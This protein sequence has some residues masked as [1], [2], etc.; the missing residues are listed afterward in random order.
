MI[1]ALTLLQ[2][3]AFPAQEET[4]CTL[5]GG[6][7]VMIGWSGIDTG[8]NSCN[9]CSCSAANALACTVMACETTE[10][11]QSLVCKLT[12]GEE[13]PSGWS[14]HDTGSNW[15]NTC[16]CSADGH[17]LCSLALCIGEGKV[18]VTPQ[19]PAGGEDA[20]EMDCEDE[21]AE[22]DAG[23]CVLAGGERVADG[24]HGS[25]T[26]GNAC[27]TCTCR[28]GVLGCTRR[29]CIVDELPLL[30]ISTDCT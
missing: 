2:H 30:E 21:E 17:L 4:G 3:L 1:V 14:G 20:H 5:T 24:W 8:A 23:A 18:P 15:C 12:G 26:G 16:R 25:D 19:Q 9:T 27:N 22:K 10:Q 7:Q 13:V 6:E 29:G 11:T 28:E